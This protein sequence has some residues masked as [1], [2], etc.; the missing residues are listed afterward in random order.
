MV[1]ISAASNVESSGL[2]SFPISSSRTPRYFVNCYSIEIL[3]S[4]SFKQLALPSP[5]PTHE[6]WSLNLEPQLKLS[7]SGGSALPGLSSSMDEQQ[8]FV[9]PKR[10]NTDYPVGFTL[11]H[12]STSLLTWSTPGYRHRPVCN[13]FTL[14]LRT[15]RPSIYTEHYTVIFAELCATLAAKTGSSV[16]ALAPWVQPSCSR[17]SALPPPSPAR[18]HSPPFSDCHAPWE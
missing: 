5:T 17:P 3:L 2:L 10:V 7:W 8:V 9:P 6:A 11:S 13:P 15:L 14:S 1:G 12:F 16:P 4:T 18:A